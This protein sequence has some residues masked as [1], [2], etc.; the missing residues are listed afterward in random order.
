M[1]NPDHSLLAWL[2]SIIILGTILASTCIFVLESYPV[3]SELER[4]EYYEFVCVVIFS[5]EY[6]TRF[7]FHM[8]SSRIEFVFTP[9]NMID[10]LA[11]LPWYMEILLATDHLAALRVLRILRLFRLLRHSNDL[12]MFITCISRSLDSFKLLALFLG[13]AVLIFSSL[14]WYAERGT[15]DPSSGLWIRSDG[16]ESPFKSIPGTFWW[17]VVTMT[18]VGYGDTFPVETFGKI[19]ATMAMI[20]GILVLAL[21]LSIVGTNFSAVYDERQVEADVAKTLAKL[22]G[23]CKSKAEQLASTASEL[24]AALAAAD[25]A[26]SQVLAMCHGAGGAMEGV[27]LPA[28]VCMERLQGDQ[29]TVKA[30]LTQTATFL[31]SSNCAIALNSF[32][33]LTAQQTA[34]PAPQP[35]PPHPSRASGLTAL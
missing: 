17:A 27:N 25:A 22:S 33:P 16:S 6:A 14:M 18:T 10:L 19:V 12:K 9:F 23:D 29:A 15:Y 30:I 1:E 26:F 2:I 32:I 8:G 13:F 20:G 11:I 28:S 3:Y 4:L 31:R 24:D 34:L 7:L 35:L 5:L 21:P